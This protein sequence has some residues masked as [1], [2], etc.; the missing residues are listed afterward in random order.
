[1]EETILA[2]DFGTSSSAAAL[3][4]GGTVELVKEPSSGSWSWPSAVC[5]TDDGLSVG[6]IA[7]Q[8]KRLRPELYRSEF[9]RDL[10]QYTPIELDGQS[11]PPEHL[12]TAMLGALKSEAERVH[13]GAIHRAVVT[14]PASYGRA[15]LRRRLMISA[16]EAAGFPVT[17]L[18]AEPVAA[19]MA[20][21]AGAAFAEGQLVLVYDF[22]GGTFDTALIRIGPD[23][24]HEV[25]GH[26]ALDD[27]GGRDIDALIYAELRTTGDPALASMLSEGGG[28]GQ[29]NRVSFGDLSRRIK[30][31]L[32]DMTVAEDLFDPAN[33]F[34]GLT[35]SRLIQ[36]VTPLL[37]GT[38]QCCRELLDRC[39]LSPDQVTGVLLVGGSIRMPVV[40]E[41]VAQVFD[42]PVRR[43]RD[44]ELAV[45]LGAANWAGQAAQRFSAA[46]T[47]EA[48][49]L[50]LR[51]PIPGGSG[52]LLK[53]RVE[54]GSSCGPDQSVALL[55]LSDGAIHELRMPSEMGGTIAE[56]H[57]G[58]GALV[59][60]TD[61]L[62]TLALP[63][64]EPEPA[65]EISGT[66]NGSADV[67][68]E[69]SLSLPHDGE[70]TAVCFGRL[71]GKLVLATS[72]KD[73]AVRVWDAATGELLASHNLHKAAVLSAVFGVI[74]HRPALVT[75][76]VDGN[77]VIWDLQRRSQLATDDQFDTAIRALAFA[78]H[79]N[80]PYLAI[81][82][83]DG[84]VWC[85]T[86]TRPQVDL[87]VADWRH[88]FDVKVHALAFIRIDGSLKLAIGGED[89]IVEVWDFSEEDEDE[90]ET[91][92]RYDH[93]RSV[94]ALA[95]A[96]FRGRPLL[97]IAGARSSLSLWHV[98]DDRVYEVPSSHPGQVRAVAFGKLNRRTVL[99]SGGSDNTV[100][101]WDVE[102][103]QRL[104]TFTA[105]KD[106]IRAVALIQH[107]DRTYLATASAD[108][109]AMIIEITP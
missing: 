55:R 24:R 87:A 14:V 57:Y 63:V 3:V 72:S 8:R 80:V 20:P 27:C 54:R 97:V 96:S 101:V 107:D 2:I 109:T 100:I 74:G 16:A 46:V 9:K 103:C 93:D 86:I 28:Q 65:P 67:T 17:E 76:D 56:L 64:P 95:A 83:E 82:G 70:V 40:G 12:V 52:G 66:P 62:V 108:K 26:S 92:E 49:Q 38:H 106:K 15:D 94:R 7:E 31:Q 105:H 78:T 89:D 68:R 1:M 84:S 22:G 85:T 90:D 71:A 81:G 41:I 21:V 91:I 11:F 6:T 73:T 23:G 53:W 39:R 13:G 34:V 30:H 25:L 88:D 75:G 48:A 10:G 79:D 33:L 36:L 60:S 5:L 37:A 61:W 4:A 99:A 58:V 18:L 32:S 35:R 43:V 51:W 19:A 69:W 104:R 47:P 59:T 45:V 102:T 98:A 29:R 77:V 50:P 42:R 44:P